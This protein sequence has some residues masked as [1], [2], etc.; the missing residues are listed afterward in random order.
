MPG[1]SIY[2]S[3]DMP[4]SIAVVSSTAAT[5]TPVAAVTGQVVR[6]YKM[7]LLSSGTAILTPQD[8][9]TP[10]SGGIPMAANGSI[11][12]DADGCPWYI[13]SP[14]NAFTIA[15]S[16]AG[17]TISGCIYYQQNKWQG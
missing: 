8:G 10:L 4:Y 16:G 14:G 15:N 13:T 2:P 3:N 5:I 9:S 17:V 7:Y 1:V 6:V 12:L 11:V